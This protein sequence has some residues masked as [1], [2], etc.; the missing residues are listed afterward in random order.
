MLPKKIVFNIK[1][2]YMSKKLVMIES[3]WQHIFFKYVS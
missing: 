1:I 3:D 2:I